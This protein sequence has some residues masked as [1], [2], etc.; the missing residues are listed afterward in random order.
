[1]IPKNG[2]YVVRTA[3]HMARRNHDSGA[4]EDAT[5]PNTMSSIDANDGFIELLSDSS[6]LI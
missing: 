2:L 4:P 3:Q 5:G 1:L 6:E